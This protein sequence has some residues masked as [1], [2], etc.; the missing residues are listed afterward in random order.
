[1]FFCYF[2]DDPGNIRNQAT[3]GGG[4]LY[5]IGCYAILCGRYLFESEPL[6]SIALVDRDPA[7]STDRTTSALLDFGA[8]RQVAFTVST[9][10]CRYQRI[11]VVGTQGRIE[12]FVPFNAPR[13]G[14]MTIAVDAG[15][16]LDGSGI[17]TEVLP[18]ADQ[19]QLQAE[20]FS[21]RIRGESAPS[22]GVDDAIAQLRVID[23]LWRSER[24]GRW[25]NI[26]A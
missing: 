12:I 22:W 25:E 10:S 6:R 16:A 23:A 5:D 13:G 18:N 26:D 17:D 3:I 14:A 19:Y 8:G 20:A 7:L 9:Q 21:R 4:A 2:N 15:G 1:V 24:S 11:N